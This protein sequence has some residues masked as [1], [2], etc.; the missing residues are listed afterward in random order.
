M[1][2]FEKIPIVIMIIIIM[3]ML[4]ASCN[5][6]QTE[7]NNTADSKYLGF[8][9]TKYAIEDGKKYDCEDTIGTTFAMD[10]FEN[11][12]GQLYDG[13]YSGEYTNISWKDTNEGIEIQYEGEVA[14]VLIV[15]GEQLVLYEDDNNGVIFVKQPENVRAKYDIWSY[16]FSGDYYRAH[17]EALAEYNEYE[18]M[19]KAKTGNYYATQ[20]FGGFKLT[21]DNSGYC[22]GNKTETAVTVD[23]DRENRTMKLVDP[24]GYVKGEYD[25]EWC[26]E[27]QEYFFME[28]RESEFE[29]YYFK[30]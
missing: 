2:H 22:Y 27:T 6:Q 3:S 21:N 14:W 13:K 8:W 23:I 7:S 12:T 24:T 16:D 17:D 30:Y 25:I 20:D 19:I 18:R 5:N 29:R 10:L 11:Y 1:K 28:V 15:E 9:E 4:L 26:D